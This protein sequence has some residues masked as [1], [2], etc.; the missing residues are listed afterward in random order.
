MPKV[1]FQDETLECPEGA[2]LRMVLT[3]AAAALQQRSQSD[4][5]PWS[6]E[7]WRLRLQ[8]RRPGLGA[9]GRREEA[10]L[11]LAWASRPPSLLVALAP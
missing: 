1:Q 5:L 7:L 9:D 4:Q 10:D 3:R 2:N 8:G 11:A 6:R